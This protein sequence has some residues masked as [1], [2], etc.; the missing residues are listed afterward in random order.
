MSI[1][2]R[3]ISGLT[4]NQ[5]NDGLITIAQMQG[6]PGF[7]PNA[8]VITVSGSGLPPLD[9]AIVMQLFPSGH[10]S[11]GTDSLGNISAQ[12]TF[13]NSGNDKLFNISGGGSATF[14]DGFWQQAVRGVCNNAT[15]VYAFS[16]Q[17]SVYDI[18]TDFPSVLNDVPDNLNSTTPS[19]DPDTNEGN[20]QISFSYTNP[21]SENP[22]AF[23][24]MR[25]D[26]SGAI[27][28]GSVPRDALATD[29]TF[30]DFVFALGTYEYSVIAYKYGAPNAKSAASSPIS[31]VFDATIPD[32]AITM[33]LVIDIA[34]AT[35]LVF[36]TDP[37]GIYTLIPGQKHDTLYQ[38]NDDTFLDVKIPNP[39]AKGY[40]AGQK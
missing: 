24:I 25:D 7:G 28:V 9:P 20:V 29:Y 10:S 12:A 21:T 4:F 11:S 38:R 22:D 23:V 26:G 31:V 34:L 27:P 19:W 13:V 3:S 15:G 36:I 14:T 6:D 5:M 30:D 2:F 35:R 37:S 40:F 33:D 16:V 17:F 18:N 1:G 39:F 32:I 8:V